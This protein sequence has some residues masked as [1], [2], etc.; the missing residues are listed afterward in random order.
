MASVTFHKVTPV[1]SSTIQLQP[2]TISKILFYYEKSLNALC[3][4]TLGST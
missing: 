3:N 2:L 4:Q 1:V